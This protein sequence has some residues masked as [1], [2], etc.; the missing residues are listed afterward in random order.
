MQTF[1]DNNGRD[2]Q[3]KVNLSRLAR[4]S[5][6]PASASRRIQRT[7]RGRRADRH[8][9]HVRFPWVLCEARQTSAASAARTGD[10]LVG[11]ALGKL[12][13]HCVKP[14]P[15]STLMPGGDAVRRVFRVIKAAEEKIIAKASKQLDEL[16]VDKLVRR[17]NGG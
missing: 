16:D 7:A 8:R 12:R 1:T 3:V 10:A 9:L 14:L 6:L 13:R 11:D 4:L 15:S 2:W 5:R 17:S